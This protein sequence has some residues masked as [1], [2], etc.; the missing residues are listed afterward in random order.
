MDWANALVGMRYQEE[1]LAPSGEP[2]MVEY[3]VIEVR[4]G[5]VISRQVS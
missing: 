4:D 1:Q 3:E 2:V 5:V